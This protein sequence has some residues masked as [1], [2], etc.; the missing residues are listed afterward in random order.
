MQR[1]YLPDIRITK[2]FAQHP[3]MNTPFKLPL[4]VKFS[5]ILVFLYLFVDILYIGQQIILPFL[6]ATVF[7][8]VLTPLVNFLERKKISRIFAITIAL[9]LAI[10]LTAALFYLIASQFSMFEK[11]IPALRGK[12]DDLLAKGSAWVSEKFNIS[13]AK[14]NDWITKA[15]ASMMDNGSTFIGKTLITISSVLIVVF[16]IPV[17]TFMILYYQPLLLEFLRK[18]FNKIHQQKL[19]EVLIQTRTIIQSYLG[20][21][22]IEAFIIATLNSIALLL[23]GIDYAILLGIIGA[24]LNVIP[25]VGGIISVALPMAVALF[26]KSPSYMLLVMGA[27]MVIQFFDNHYIT[28]KVVASKVKINALIAILVVLMGDA[29]WGIPGMFLSIPLTA[30]VKVIFEHIDPLKPWAFLLGDTMP[31]FSKLVLTLPKRKPKQ[32]T[33]HEPGKALK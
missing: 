17:Y 27:Y 11:N 29:L 18:L 21:L 14:V 23:L 30:I 22:L 33:V 7:S 6:Y 20:G 2:K 25:F 10:L 12:S 15:K 5:C 28:P 16:L 31:A 19:E 24:L 4:Y 8:I 13:H 3:K 1:Y 9:I 26:T 32:P